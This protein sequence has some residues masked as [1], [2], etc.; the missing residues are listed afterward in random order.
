MQTHHR[1]LQLL[2]RLPHLLTLPPQPLRPLI[3]LS[4]SIRDSPLVFL[5]LLQTFN[6][7]LSQLL[8]SNYLLH[9]LYFST[10]LLDI[11]LATRAALV[12]AWVSASI[13]AV[14]SSIMENLAVRPILVVETGGEEGEVLLRIEDCICAYRLRLVS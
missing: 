14:V 5:H 10:R 13:S 8:I 1:V 9:L 6:S 4:R 2:S 11:L 3:I 12:R 7:V